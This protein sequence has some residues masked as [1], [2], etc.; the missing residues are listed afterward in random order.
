M[1]SLIR[2]HELAAYYALAFGISLAL[3]L[4]LSV[5]LV[6]GL[7]ALFGPATAAFVVARASDRPTAVAELRGAATRWRV[8]PAWYLAAVALPVA[9]FAI[10]HLLYVLAGH[11]PLPIP[12]AINP[13]MFILFVLVIGEEVGWRGFLLSGLLRRRSPVAATAIVA[14]AW[15]LWHAP[16]YF[17]PGM[18]S[19]GESFL[20]F[21]AWVVPLSFLLTWLW[22]RTRSTWLTAVMHGSAN[23]GAALVF[24]TTDTGTLFVFAGLGTTVVALVLV[25]ASWPQF[26]AVPRSDASAEA[27]S[28]PLLAEA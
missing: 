4:L 14:V 15:A 10:G 8:N 21:A 7:L 27:A 6:F 24:P 18:P 3:A 20:A 2:R 17:L 23:L 12:G 9:G 22:L 16:L 28:P 26:A 13:I 25:A 5:S 19:Y 11:D 1:S